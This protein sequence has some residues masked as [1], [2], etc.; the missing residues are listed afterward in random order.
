MRGWRAS[1]SWAASETYDLLIG[2]D[3][4]V[5]SELFERAVAAARTTLVGMTLA[6]LGDFNACLGDPAVDT[7]FSCDPFAFDNDGDVDLSDFAIAP[8]IM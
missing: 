6:Q 4:A 3:T 8:R 2:K 5:Y 1:L 7:G